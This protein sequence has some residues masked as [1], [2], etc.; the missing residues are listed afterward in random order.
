MSL[1]FDYSFLQKVFAACPQP[2][3]WGPH[4][5]QKLLSVSLLMA[6]MPAHLSVD[7][8]PRRQRV[9]VARY[10]WSNTGMYWQ[11][12]GSPLQVCP[13]IVSWLTVMEPATLTHTREAVPFELG[14]IP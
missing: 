10:L 9:A 3:V 1:Q 7:P 5:F 6:E 8:R 12:A 4:S 11:P 2:Y 13:A 14:D